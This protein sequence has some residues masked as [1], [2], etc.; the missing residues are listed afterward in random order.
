MGNRAVITAS[1]HTTIGGVGIYVHWNGGPESV[2]AFLDVAR[3]R[4]YRDPSED[5]SYAMARLCGLICEFFGG[6]DSVGIGPLDSLDC[7]NFDNGV[8]VI[9]KGWKVVNRWGKGSEAMP[10]TKQ[11]NAHQLKQ[12]RGIKDQLQGEAIGA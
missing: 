9:G 11:M 10:T 12:Y 6:T 5:E 3:A 7:D 1:T 2:A 4:G 8:Y